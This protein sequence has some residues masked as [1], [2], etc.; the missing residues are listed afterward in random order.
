MAEEAV[1]LVGGE[2]YAETVFRVL[3]SAVEG[4]VIRLDVASVDGRA[5]RLSRA[6]VARDLVFA[7]CG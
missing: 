2:P 5:D 4:A 6:F 7:A 3:G 1:S